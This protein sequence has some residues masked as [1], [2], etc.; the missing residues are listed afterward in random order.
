M[1]R[2]R[3]RGPDRRRHG[4]SPLRTNHPR[5]TNLTIA[6]NPNRE[7]LSY[8]RLPSPMH[9]PTSFCPFPSF[10]LH[11]DFLDNFRLIS[12]NKAPSGSGEMIAMPAIGPGHNAPSKRPRV[13]P[14]PHTQHLIRGFPFPS[15]TTKMGR[16]LLLIGVSPHLYSSVSLHNAE[17]KSKIGWARPDRH[18]KVGEAIGEASG[19][20]N[21]SVLRP[22]D[23]EYF[24]E[25]CGLVM[26][27]DPHRPGLVCLLI[28][29][30]TS[31]SPLFIPSDCRR[32]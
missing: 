19:W 27:I 30:L 13:G 28:V 31:D 7:I 9:F 29:V 3:G 14:L 4:H 10:S 25:Q 2:R 22:I 12:D 21:S 32:D 6:P 20:S 23:W 8:T 17:S 16:S 24:C 5:L 15:P 1:H 11:P 18:I 26:I